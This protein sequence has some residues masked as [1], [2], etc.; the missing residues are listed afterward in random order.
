MA[1]S[2][3]KHM[4]PDRCMGLLNAVV[5]YIAAA[6]N[7]KTQISKLVNIGF[8]TDELVDY[9]GYSESDIEGYL[10]DCDEER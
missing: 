9:F 1:S 4:D 10:D 3:D 7:T 8:T 5:D 6:E 2:F